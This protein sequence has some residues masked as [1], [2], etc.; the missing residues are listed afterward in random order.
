MV[1]TPLN[2][3]NPEDDEAEMF[4]DYEQVHKKL[5]FE[6]GARV[7]G[8]FVASGNWYSGVIVNSSKLKY[9]GKTEK[10]YLIIVC[11]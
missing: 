2:V 6:I 8:N 4:E 3:I 11:K 1:N 5:K 10:M 9:K 7:E